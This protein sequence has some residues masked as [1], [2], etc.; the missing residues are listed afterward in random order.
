MTT[1]IYLDSFK[2]LVPFLT[3][4]PLPPLPLDRLHRLTARR[5]GAEI[6]N[7]RKEMTAVPAAVGGRG[8]AAA[9]KGE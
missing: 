6:G 2:R 4:P 3:P 1:L 8:G 5:E 9:A 7:S